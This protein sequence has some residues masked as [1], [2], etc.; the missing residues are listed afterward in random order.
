MSYLPTT[1]MP[2]S[3]TQ[4][5]TGLDACSSLCTEIMPLSESSTTCSEMPS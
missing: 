2:V 4:R 5:L 3:T 1:F